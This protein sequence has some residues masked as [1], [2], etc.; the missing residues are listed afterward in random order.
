VSNASNAAARTPM[1]NPRPRIERLAIGARH[2]CFVVDDALL[3]PE[4]WVEHAVA[5][6][7]RFAELDRNAYPGPELALPEDATAQLEAF[8]SRHLRRG[9]GGRRTLSATSRLS[10]ATRPPASLRPW[11]CF[12]HVDRLQ[13]RRG[14]LIAA[15]VLYLFEDARLG[16]T[17]FYMPK[18]PPDEI[19][20][21]VQAAAEWPPDL[22]H[23]ET[24]IA[25]GY[26]TESNG[27][28]QKVLAV[29]PRWNRMIVYPGTVM[30]SGDI[31]APEL[32]SEDPRRGR[33][34]INGF[35][36]CTRALAA[37]A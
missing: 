21:L 34:T 9:L 25:R 4:R 12:C 19:E 3:E 32:L 16:G 27:W 17:G 15:S 14:Q 8:F 28:F 37:T 13:A 6:R 2:A 30:H 29:E 33:L 23:A 1:F 36:A 7:D 10:L 11:Q 35:F 18:R 24:G 5:N 31:A 22:F 20:R 26:M